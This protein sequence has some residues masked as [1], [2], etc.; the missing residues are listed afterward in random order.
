MQNESLP[1]VS[2]EYREGAS[3]K[4]YRAT[5]EAQ[6]GGYVVLFAYGRRGS[7]LNTGTKTHNPVPLAD[8]LNLYAKLVRS[9]TAKGYKP[10]AG[11]QPSAGSGMGYSVPGPVRADTG[12]RAQL[13]N[14]VEEIDAETYLDDDRFCAQE[15][16][17]GRRMLVRKSAGGLLAAN[18]DG[19]T[20]GMPDTVAAS[21]STV[22]GCFVLDGE[23]VGE[24]FHAFDLLED[25]GTD[26]RQEQY[27]IRL[28]TLRMRLAHLDADGSVRVVETATGPAKRL[29]LTGL[30]AA[31][32]EGVVFK[33]LHAPWSAGR[34]ANGGCAVKL[35]FWAS[36]SCV[37]SGINARRSVAVALDGTAVGNVTIPPNHV[38]PAVGQVVEVRYLYVAGPGGS[39]YQP[40][41]LGVRDDVP[42]ADCTRTK[43]QL[44]TKPSQET[45]D[46]AA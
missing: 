34:P 38:L 11:T 6:G 24:I 26:L 42:P 2:L 37:V 14:P 25:G 36:C 46:L 8:A 40:V 32:R 10:A 19:L 13:L 3:D 9:K 31:D 30:K 33:D 20:T 44:K 4:V 29:L 43:Q 15:K 27:R 12:L 22:P 18:R 1:S 7:A 39:L 28:Q 17:D 45:E 5:V 21:L 23:C 16:F 41:Y 35:K